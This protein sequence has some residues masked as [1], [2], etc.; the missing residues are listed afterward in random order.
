[1]A[2]QT[3]GILLGKEKIVTSKSG[4]EHVTVSY[5]LRSCR[6]FLSFWGSLEKLVK[7]FCF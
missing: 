3:N 7:M 2:S 4:L 5:C 6:V 1:M